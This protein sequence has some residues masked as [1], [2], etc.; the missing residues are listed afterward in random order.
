MVLGNPC[1]RVVIHRLRTTGLG[2]VKR[3]VQSL[4]LRKQST[5]TAQKEEMNKAQSKTKRRST[6][7]S[8]QQPHMRCRPWALT[9]RT[10][11]CDGHQQMRQGVES[12]ARQVLRTVTWMHT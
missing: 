9:A 1:E 4:V 2:Y 11:T 6:R 5:R 8:H 12:K 10:A 7:S 3:W